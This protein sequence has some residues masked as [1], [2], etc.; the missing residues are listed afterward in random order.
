MPLPR[1]VLV[2]AVLERP[3]APPW[4]G[5]VPFP[6]RAESW[7]GWLLG[8]RWVDQAAGTWTG[9]VRYRREGLLYEHW[10]AGELLT[11]P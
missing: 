5:T 11:D 1:P 7:P 4:V 8:W 9:L 2:V 10:I 6:E 3:P